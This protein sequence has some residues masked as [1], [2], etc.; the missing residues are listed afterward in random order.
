MQYHEVPSAPAAV[1]LFA[2]LYH[3]SCRHP[4]LAGTT[5]AH[6][7]GQSRPFTEFADLR[8]EAMAGRIMTASTI[9]ERFDVPGVQRWMRHADVA[10]NTNYSPDADIAREGL[11]A[12]I[13]N[14]AI[15]IH[16]AERGAVEKGWAAVALDPPRPWIIFS[17][18][19]SLAQE[20]R[21]S[22][23]RFL[24]ARIVFAPKRRLG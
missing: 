13:E 22:Q 2:I 12:D 7:V 10:D 9:L 1:L 17:E 5:L 11:R 15:A 20:G 19:P 3:E 18:L 24:L 14:L 21:R 16:D 4:V 6:S 23:A 8:P